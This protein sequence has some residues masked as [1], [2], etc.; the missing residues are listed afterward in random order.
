MSSKKKVKLPAD[1]VHEVHKYVIPGSRE[2]HILEGLVANRPGGH[3]LHQKPPPKNLYKGGYT[4]AG[5]FAPI[6][7]PTKMSQIAYFEFKPTR[8]N[9]PKPHD[10]NRKYQSYR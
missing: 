5:M 6:K 4:Q 1:L 9:V 3:G 10:P 2:S 8:G 7:P